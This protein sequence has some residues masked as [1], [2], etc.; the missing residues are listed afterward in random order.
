MYLFYNDVY[1]YFVTVYKIIHKFKTLMV[2]SS[3]KLNILGALYVEFKI[4]KFPAVFKKIEKNHKKVPNQIFTCKITIIY[5]Q[6]ILD[7][8]FS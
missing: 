5:N 3:G 1:V 7:F 2:V 6:I 4:K 8:C